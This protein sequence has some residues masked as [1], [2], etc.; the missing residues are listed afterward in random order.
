MGGVRILT[1]FSE[2][3]LFSSEFW[4][5]KSEFWLNSEFWGKSQ[6]SDFKL[7]IL[8]FFSEFWLFSQNSEIKLRILWDEIICTTVSGV[9]FKQMCSYTWISTSNPWNCCTYYFIPLSEVQNTIPCYQ[10]VTL[11]SWRSFS[12]YGAIYLYFGPSYIEGILA[13]TFVQSNLQ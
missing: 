13:D 7:R 3:W 1:F 2:F 10:A 5:K 6:N 8:T 9:T 11:W 12:L 4:E